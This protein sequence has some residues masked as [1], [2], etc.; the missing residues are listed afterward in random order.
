MKKSCVLITAVAAL[1]A[2]AGYLTAKHMEL[3][4]TDEHD[5]DEFE[6]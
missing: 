5:Y 2:A 3:F 1:A 6:S 4:K